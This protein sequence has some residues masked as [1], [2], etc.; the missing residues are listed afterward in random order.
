MGMLDSG[1]NIHVATRDTVEAMG[2]KIFKSA[3]RGIGTVKA[4]AGV[5]SSGIITLDNPVG[6]MQVVEEARVCLL[7]TSELSKRDFSTLFQSVREGGKCILSCGGQEV[8]VVEP[9]QD[10]LHYVDI[11]ELI[12]KTKEVVPSVMA[13]VQRLSPERMK[14]L[15]GGVM[16]LHRCLVLEC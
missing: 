4:G 8:M 7:S 16:H 13:A 2:A 15:V 1:A 3:G 5:R 6:E 9:N 11:A 10:G 12:K 14:R